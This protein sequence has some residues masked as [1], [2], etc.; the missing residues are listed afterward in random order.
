MGGLEAGGVH[1]AL[2]RVGERLGGGGEPV[3]SGAEWPKPGRSSASMSKLAL[4]QREHRL[5]APPGVADAVD[6]HQRLACAAAM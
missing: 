6:Q 1:L 5:P 4:E 2:D 3:G